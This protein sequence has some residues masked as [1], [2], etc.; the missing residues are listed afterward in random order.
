MKKI[1]L[2]AGLTLLA[3]VIVAFPAAAGGGGSS[4]VNPGGI[5][6]DDNSACPGTDYTSIQ[7]A[8][9]A[10]P[11]GSKIQVCPGTYNEQVV[12]NKPLTIDGVS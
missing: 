5:V 1:A 6:V 11:A 10:S 12:I 9:T 7:A 2:A 8:V 3:A 4:E